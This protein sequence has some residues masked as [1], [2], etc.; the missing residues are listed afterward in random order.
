[1]PVSIE[2]K[3]QKLTDTE[4]VLLRPGM[5]IGSIKP[6]TEEVY[7]LDKRSYRFTP[8]EI[9]YNPGFL[10]LFDE[11]VSNSVDE[12]KRN[13]KLNQ[14]KIKIDLETNYISVWDNGGIPVE[15]HKEYDEWVPEMIFSNLKTGSNFDDTEDRIV[16]GTNGVGSTL[17]NIF[18]KEFVIDTCD[19]K[20][21]FT[22]TFKNNMGSRTKP[23]IKSQRRG[24][25]EI[26]YLPD[27]EKF[28]MKKIDKAS[29]LMIE[30]RL[31]DLAA[32]NPKLKITLN[33]EVISFK[34][35]KAYAE[36]Y[37]TPVFYEE[38]KNWKIGIGHSTSGFKAVS[39]VNSVETKDGGT[40]V[41]NVAWQITQ[42]L[43]EKIKRKHR[44]DVK[45]NELR[46]HLFL[47]IDCTIINPAFS[48]QTKEKLI[49]QPSEFGSTHEL[50][51]RTLR[52]VLNSEIIQ[53]VLDWIQR[54]KAA[55]ERA[56]LRKLNKGLDKKKVVKLIDAK[57]RGDRSKC[58]LAIFEGDSA[59]SAFR[60]YRDPQ[61]QGAF[62]L[63]GKFINVR[64]IVDSKVVQNKE[65]QSL[66]AAIG[67]KIGHEPKD[68]R[69]G[70]ILLYT[71]AD[72]D[73]N[74]ISALLINFLGKYWPELFEEGRVCK[75]ETPLMVAKKGK[76]TLSFYSDEEYKEWET[77]Q[78]SLKSW[79]IEY[80]K[81][82]A[83]LEDE[84][85]K[86][87]IKNPQVF[88][89]TKDNEFD[90]TLDIWFS[91]DSTPRKKKIL[92]EDVYIKKNE[93]SLF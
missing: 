12:H 77:K 89:L 81:G 48:S 88:I 38:S 22:Q 50:S 71:D 56:K 53:S 51:E 70:K 57:K 66:M 30:K 28:G 45:P 7:L 76:E 72:V 79:D 49:T 84:E 42:F 18:S 47:F 19:G 44:V 36:M 31:Y 20:K 83:A 64:E 2:K 93:K 69:Y 21:R 59:S 46:Q 9:T 62:P 82:L 27:F 25:T 40:H 73:G 61:T 54:K 85:Y 58:T 92:G 6:Q 65:V 3:Y 39:F 23:K 24:F 90:S 67:L 1:M 43:R 15:I 33:D 13:S 10:K 35:F 68:L 8:K 11:I 29:L 16:V 32:S 91:K 75:V 4:H 63:R 74:S 14:I 86:A 34:N 78:R 17:T 87:I 5:Y 37:T 26:T 55:E 80:K 60:R 52:Q 41:N